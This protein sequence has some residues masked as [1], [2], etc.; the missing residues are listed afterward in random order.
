MRSL[1]KASTCIYFTQSIQVLQVLN[2]LFHLE[3]ENDACPVSERT[4]PPLICSMRKMEKK[5]NAFLLARDVLTLCCKLRLTSMTRHAH[6]CSLFP[7]VEA[8]CYFSSLLSEPQL[9]LLLSAIN[10]LRIM[11]RQLFREMCMYLGV[12]LPVVEKILYS[13]YILNFFPSCTFSRFDEFF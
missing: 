3:C 7:S 4:L 8:L 11:R 9:Q 1:R 10:N 12:Q 5:E 2:S 6:T 13:S